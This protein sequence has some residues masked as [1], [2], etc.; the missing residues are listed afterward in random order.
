MPFRT[1]FLGKWLFNNTFLAHLNGGKIPFE[2]L[3]ALTYM[4]RESSMNSANLRT[5]ARNMRTRRKR[6]VLL[7]PQPNT[8]PSGRIAVHDTASLACGG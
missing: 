8:V 5:K 6:T 2:E 7:L 3:V 1:L 4:Q